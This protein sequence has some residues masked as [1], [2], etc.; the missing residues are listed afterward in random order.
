MA[1]HPHLRVHIACRGHGAHAGQ[2]GQAILRFHRIPAILPKRHH[3]RVHIG[4]GFPIG[5]IDLRIA[6]RMLHRRADAVA[7][8]A[9]GAHIGE[10]G[11]RQL[12]AVK[13]IVALLRAVHAL[14]QRVGQRLGLEIIAKA[15]HVA[16]MCANAAGRADHSLGQILV[17]HDGLLFWR[18]RHGGRGGK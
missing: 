13:T 10:G 8:G 9:L 4:G 7:P 6:V 17:G 16:F 2:P 12:L 3:V 15:R 14:R 1:G 5:Q 11:A 18:H